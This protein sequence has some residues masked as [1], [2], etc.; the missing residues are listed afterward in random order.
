MKTLEIEIR[1][2]F[3]GIRTDY[4]IEETIKTSLKILICL[5]IINLLSW[6]I[7]KAVPDQELYDSPRINVNLNI[8]KFIGKL[9]NL[10]G[11]LTNLP[12][13]IVKTLIEQ[14]ILDILLSI[15]FIQVENDNHL[16]LLSNYTQN[17]VTS[18]Q[19]I[20]FA[21]T[22]LSFL[23]GL[24]L[25]IVPLNVIS[26]EL[27]AKGKKV[28]Q[29]S[30]LIAFTSQYQDWIIKFMR[31]FADSIT[32]SIRNSHNLAFEDSLKTVFLNLNSNGLILI[33]VLFLTSLIVIVLL[34]TALILETL[35]PIIFNLS[36]LAYSLP[37][38]KEI[39]NKMAV[40]SMFFFL[41]KPLT[42]GLITLNAIIL[43]D[44]V[45]ALTPIIICVLDLFILWYFFKISNSAGAQYPILD[46][47]GAGLGIGIHVGTALALSKIG[48]FSGGK[49]R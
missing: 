34:T 13:N 35:S 31:S 37:V 16:E 18:I 49:K 14:L 11:T 32:W 3:K 47:V 20:T 43:T 19:S 27:A 7:V 21:I 41:L 44:L 8:D 15:E 29:D 46:Q 25:F 10:I 12:Q 33:T 30:I 4:Y 48:I 45:S 6:P 22:Q 36:L 2:S 28:A 24:G 5:S 26:T 1:S 23:I 9:Q 38:G 39:G 40:S 17:T 42:W